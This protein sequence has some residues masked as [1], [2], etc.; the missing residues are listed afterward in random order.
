MMRAAGYF[1]LD[2]EDPERLNPLSVDRLREM[3]ALGK[4]TRRTWVVSEETGE[5]GALSELVDL[6]SGESKSTLNRDTQKRTGSMMVVGLVL[7]AGV[8]ATFLMY[9]WVSGDAVVSFRATMGSTGGVLDVLVAASFLTGSQANPKWRI[10]LQLRAAFGLLGALIAFVGVGFAAEF[11]QMLAI[12]GVSVQLAALGMVLYNVG[13][14]MSLGD[15]EHDSD[16]TVL[17]ARLLV[18]GM[19]LVVGVTAYWM[20]SGE[21]ATALERAAEEVERQLPA[22]A[23]VVFR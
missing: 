7:L 8:V 21:L 12:S 10:L 2:V 4:I 19:V 3:H 11:L 14:L 6:K 16:R 5:S 13:L 9:F 22:E 15:T 18:A 17:G 23:P 1:F 20:V